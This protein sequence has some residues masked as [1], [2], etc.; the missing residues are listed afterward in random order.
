MVESFPERDMCE[1]GWERVDWL[2]EIQS[3]HEM[4]KC[5]WRKS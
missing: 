3:K 2:V 1:G 5:G 4:D